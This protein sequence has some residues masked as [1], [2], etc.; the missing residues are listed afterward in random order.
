MHFAHVEPARIEREWPI[1]ADIL[2]PALRQDPTQTIEGLHKRLAAG[3]EQLIEVSGGASGLM[4]LEV[5]EELVCWV[6]YAAGRIDGGPKQRMQFFRDTMEHL[7]SVAKNAGCTEVRLCG[8]DW[9]RILP[10]YRPADGF[11]NELRKAL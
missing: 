6:K 9:A 2:A 8:R 3:A 7:A 10:D 5:T 11:P 4:V 1:F